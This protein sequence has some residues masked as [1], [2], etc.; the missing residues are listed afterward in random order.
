MKIA[1]SANSAGLDAPASPVFGRCPIYTFVDTDSM[2]AESVENPAMSAAG[3]AGIQAA[4]FIVERGAQAVLTGNVGP[5]AFDVFQAADVPVYLSGE[6]TVREMV[7]AYKAGQLPNAGGANVQAHAGMGMGRGRGMGMGM[8]RRRSASPSQAQTPQAESSAPRDEE[9]SSLKETVGDL[10][11]Q[12]AQ[13]MD[14]IDQLDN[15]DENVDEE[16]K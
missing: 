9:V 4:Q 7:E 5:N 1:I 8:G 11:Q 16:A 3:G 12:L 6:G 10:R 2:E 15:V 14:R 13:V